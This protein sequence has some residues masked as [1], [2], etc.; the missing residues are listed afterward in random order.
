M[1]AALVH[2]LSVDNS[3]H[4]GCLGV[5]DALSYHVCAVSLGPETAALCRIPLPRGD[6][7]ASQQGPA[8]V[9]W[10]YLDDDLRITR[11]SKGSL[12]V[13]TKQ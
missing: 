4:I 12:F 6:R 13:H 10:L 2:H 11:G 5:F 8:Y 9:D 1:P 3:K 7:S